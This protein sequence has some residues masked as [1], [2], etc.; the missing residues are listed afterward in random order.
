MS[1]TAH[2]PSTP[3]QP[4]RPRPARRGCA[5]PRGIAGAASVRAI[6]RRTDQDQRRPTISPVRCRHSITRLVTV[7]CSPRNKSTHPAAC[8]ASPGL[9]VYDGRSDLTAVTNITKQLISEEDDVVALVGRWLHPSCSLPG[10]SRRRRGGRFSMSAVLRR[11]LPRLATTSS[12]C[13]S[14]TTCR[15]RPG[16]NSPIKQGEPR[17]RSTTALTTTRIFSRLIS[18]PAAHR[19]GRADS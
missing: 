5:H 8:W 13:H 2:T 17:C 6:E 9:I 3:W 16:R 4:T 18:K 15:R 10:R 1:L 11:S 19:F 12:W 14:A 7:R